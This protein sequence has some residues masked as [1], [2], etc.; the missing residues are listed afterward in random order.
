MLVY[1]VHTYTYIHKRWLG[2]TL[3]P[4]WFALSFQK[5][6]NIHYIGLKLIAA[7]GQPYL[8][9][10]FILQSDSGDFHATLSHILISIVDNSA[11]LSL[12]Q[13]YSRVGGT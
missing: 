10:F 7:S 11:R 12:P 13:C 8:I 9:F 3:H 4:N 6:C 2:Q 5:D 1:V